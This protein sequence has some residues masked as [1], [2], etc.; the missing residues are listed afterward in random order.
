[1]AARAG[2]ILGAWLW[3]APALL[4]YHV[5]P[6][7]HI[8][9]VGW[10]V[11][12]TVYN[13]G[14]RTATATLQQWSDAGFRSLDITSK[15]PVHGQQVWTHADLLAEGIATI[16]TEE[17]KI[18][19]KLSYRFESSGSL[20]ES[21]VAPDNAGT[22]WLVSNAHSNRF[23]SFSVLVANFGKQ[24]T[25]VS[26]TALKNGT[27]VG[28]AT[29]ALKPER[30]RAATSVQ[31]WGLECSEVD[32]VLISSEIPIPP[33]LALL[34]SQDQSR[35]LFVAG[36]PI[37]NAGGERRFFVPLIAENPWTT[38]VVIYNPGTDP[39]RF[40][41]HQ[42]DDTGIEILT[43]AQK[44]APKETVVLS[45]SKE[46]QLAG[47]GSGLITG[48]GTLSVK[49][50]YGCAKSES[51][52]ELF[53]DGETSRRWLLPSPL[54]GGFDRFVIAIQNPAAS[55]TTAFL[56]AFKHSIEVANAQVQLG[57]MERYK[58]PTEQVLGLNPSEFEMISIEASQPVSAPLAITGSAVEERDVFLRGQPL[59][60]P[61]KLRK[62]AFLLYD[63]AEFAGGYNPARDFSVEA[64]SGPN[65]DVLILEDTTIT[66][67]TLYHVNPNRYL[68][69][70]D[71][72]KERNMGDPKTLYDFI[73]R[74]KTDFPAERYILAF[75][76]HGT[77][78]QGCCV[79]E[80]SADLLS[81]DEMQRAVRQAGG[82]DLMLF[83]APCL[84][85]ELESV[86]ELR[87]W[88]DVYVGSE[89]L[90]S[91][92]WLGTIQYIRGTVEEIPDISNREL[93]RNIVGSISR[94][95]PDIQTT[96]GYQFGD[97]YT[98]SAIDTAAVSRLVSDMNALNT[99]LL[100]DPESMNDRIGAIWDSVQNYS[101]FFSIDLY[102][103]LEKYALVETR[104]E[105]ETLIRTVQESLRACILAEGHGPANAGSHGL[106][107][108]FPLPFAIAYQE[109]YSD[110]GYGLDFAVDTKWPELI[111]SYKKDRPHRRSFFP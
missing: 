41:F 88:T 6:I 75:Y 13:E 54:Q 45:T 73:M 76:D 85:G 10:D 58:A 80:T 50:S 104:P 24:A 44:V 90:S 53:A 37:D 93:G 102:D 42:Y 7:P 95:M 11:A 40:S 18:R 68:A 69:V 81:M 84:M 86:Y 2:L 59:S 35:H 70:I 56:R 46:G 110:P 34:A 55:P 83:T 49:L 47:T 74:A 3:T 20:W 5:F 21:F 99:A 65:L 97:R 8:P 87:D 4:A 61:M 25:T 111:K 78:W 94:N 15:I 98:M 89:D 77:G 66:P 108:Y 105:I 30:K 43:V 100:A 23:S 48:R 79:D 106:S 14:D 1:M 51:S 57:P 33:P 72:P 63:D 39:A 19:V 60:D 67:T 101:G 22:Q 103:F 52:W 62:W 64:Y 31:L 28:S 29:F 92:I 82:V 96:Y 12:V 71:A 17:E 26:V 109:L 16:R 27:E 107:I 9:G 91:Y 38:R 36:D 32:A